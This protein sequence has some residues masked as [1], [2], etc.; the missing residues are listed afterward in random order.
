LI[1]ERGSSTNVG[2]IWDESADQFC[3]INTTDTATTAGN[4]TVDSYAKLCAGVGFFGST[5]QVTGAITAN[6]GINIDN[7]NIDGTT[8]ALSSSNLT[9]DVAGDIILD[10]NTANWRFKDNG[11]AVLEIGRGGGGSGPSFYSAISDADMV[12][13]GNDGGSAITALTL[14]MSDAG[15]AIFNSDVRVQNGAAL[16]AYR[17][18]NSA[19]A[20]LF[21]DTGEKLYIRNSWGNKDIVML[22]TGEVGIGTNAPSSILHISSTSPA[23]YIQDSD[24]TSTHSITSMS[25]GTNFTVDTR[26]SDGTFVS[27]DY[28]IVKDASGANY[29]R[30]FTQ[31]AERMR[32]KADGNVGIGTATPDHKLRVEGTTR[33]NDN[34]SISSS[35][36]GHPLNVNGIIYCIAGRVYVNDNYGFTNSNGTTGFYP[37]ATNGLDFKVGASVKMRL[38]PDGNLG[39]GTTAPA[40][41]LDIIGSNGTVS[42]TPDTDTE[43]LVIRNNDR[44][45]IQILSSEAN[46]KH[47]QIIFGSAS[48]INGANINGAIMKSC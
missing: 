15:A 24:A 18:G 34:V 44:A 21:M 16:K 26:Q 48:D 25:G 11:T 45:G 9:L 41:K 6:A 42:G 30:W 8:I 46:G 20:S 17:S 31:G 3:F 12:F 33:L 5:L 13:K 27:T 37:H 32:I 4:V 39:I 19:Y 28:Q 1:I 14:D 35:Y 40:G 7:I 38:N 2:L 22:R 36:N 23:F 10:S 29:Q 43:E 47:S